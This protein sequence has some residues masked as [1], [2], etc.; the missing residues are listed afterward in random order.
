[1]R[2]TRSWIHRH[3]SVL[4]GLTVVAL[5][6]FFVV[7]AGT[8][9]RTGRPGHHAV[10]V[11]SHATH[12]GVAAPPLTAG[13]PPEIRVR[14]VACLYSSD[15]AATDGFVFTGAPNRLGARAPPTHGCS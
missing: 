2:G 15:A 4:C 7:A 6:T 14:E 5:L 11:A 12:N 8:D 1:M 3:R 9:H 10:I 13:T